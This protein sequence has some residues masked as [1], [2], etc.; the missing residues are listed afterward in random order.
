MNYS[1]FDWV[2]AK[3]SRWLLKE[4]SPEKPYLCDFNQIYRHIQPGDVLLI[5]G[6]NRASRIIRHITQS[7][8]THAALYVGELNTI[9]HQRSRELVEQYDDQYNSEKLLI[10][11]EIGLGTILSPLI[12]YKDANIRILRPTG[13]TK[14]DAQKVIGFAINSLGKKYDIRHL[15]D[16]ARYLF[17]WGF[18]PRRWRSSLFQHNAQQ[19]TE[20]ICSSMI[21]DAFQSVD[22][23]ILPLIEKNDKN[24]LEFIR[25]NTWL[26]TPSDF[27]YSP[28]F[29]VIKYPFFPLG[30]HG[31]YHNL[32]WK[33]G[34]ISN[35][36]GLNVTPLE[37]QEDNQS[38][39]SNT[40][41]SKNKK[42][43]E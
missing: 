32:P 38:P 27:D 8:W 42:I 20:D 35:D 25:R 24:K 19:P 30:I 40:T 1:F 6:R 33:E 37:S 21:A 41:S 14:A 10:E 29:D 2:I 23:P 13:L 31:A 26:Y 7:P 22:Y 34:V 17:P 16:L 15:F 43:V 18:F 9:E 39:I 5:E 12:N 3:L 28:Y 36:E 4:I 11:S